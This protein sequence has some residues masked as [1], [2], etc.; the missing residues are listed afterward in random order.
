MVLQKSIAN[1]PLVS[2]GVSLLES[3][4][5]GVSVYVGV[6]RYEGVDDVP[7]EEIKAA[8]RA[9]IVEWENTYT[10]GL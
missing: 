6:Q 8:I 10:P 4:T 9:A 1:T 7:D 5:G 3:P 2:R